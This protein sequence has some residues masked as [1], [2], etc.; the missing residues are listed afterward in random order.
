MVNINTDINTKIVLGKSRCSKCRAYDD[1]LAAK[2]NIICDTCDDF[3]YD[4]VQEVYCE[5]CYNELLGSN[6]GIQHTDVVDCPR[7]E[8]KGGWYNNCSTCSG[9]G[10]S[11]LYIKCS[12]GYQ[13]SHYYCIHGNNISSDKHD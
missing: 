9:D 5:D 4:T 11:T 7:C 12:H 2:F 8:T 13:N 10:K 1:L 3:L 6:Y